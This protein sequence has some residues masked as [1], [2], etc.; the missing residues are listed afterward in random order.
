MVLEALSQQRTLPFE[1]SEFAQRLAN[2]RRA[3]AER[4]L[5]V[6]LTHTP[7]N[8]Y[9]LTGYQT[10]GY[11]AYQVLIV[12]ERG[13]PLLLVRR[14]EEVNVLLGSWV[15]QRRIYQDTD[16][17]AEET[18]RALAELGLSSGR[19]G[20]E[21]EAW[22]FSIGQYER[23]C[24]R[25][26]AGAE[27]VDATGLIE[28]LRVV[29]SAAEIA[30]IRQ[31]AVAAAA[32]M[33][34]GMEA[35]APGRTE[36]DVAIAMHQG[37]IGAGGEYMSLPPFVAAGPR[38]QLAHATWSGRRLERGD[39]VLFE[40]SGVVRRYSA[41]LMRSAYLGSEPPAEMRRMMAAARDGLEAVIAAIGPGVP[42]EEVD[43]VNQEAYRR[44]GFD[45]GKR[46]GYSIGINFPPDWGE[47]SGLSLRPG[48]S[49]LLE[50]GMVFHTPTTVRA[51]GQPTVATSET[52]L[53]T[54]T[55]REVLT[56]FPRDLFLV[57]D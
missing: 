4:D 9:Y 35:L 5:R 15:Q 22:F 1:P 54:P 43:R 48:E 16:D 12:G 56:S 50:P 23:L 57:G 13:E 52:I 32:G 46:T 55:G 2:V 42:A 45:L 40:L 26:G 19:V 7:E 21:K 14:L 33:R 39:P 17:V 28:R 37:V 29:K 36:S 51:W 8:I 18:Y 34:A 27:V 31:A 25:L 3:M 24:R 49:R 41:A 44:H 30:C 38:A 20:L 10:A 53:V 6:L 11:Y 47:G